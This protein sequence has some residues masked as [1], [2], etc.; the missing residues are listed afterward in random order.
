[1]VSEAPT[2]GVVDR[3]KKSNPEL[4]A[5]FLDRVTVIVAWCMVS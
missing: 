5:P 1:M 3:Q 4:Q 2:I